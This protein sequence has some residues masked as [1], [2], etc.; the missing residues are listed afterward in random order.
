MADQVCME[1]AL[2]D[3]SQALPLSFKE[4]ERGSHAQHLVGMIDQRKYLK[5]AYVWKGVE[6]YNYENER[7]QDRVGYYTKIV[8]AAK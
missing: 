5:L 1:L 6:S 8:S 2:K 7:D 4:K 3:R